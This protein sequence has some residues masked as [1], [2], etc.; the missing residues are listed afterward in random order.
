M[1]TPF[2]FVPRKVAKRSKSSNAAPAVRA[3][4]S[5]VTTARDSDVDVPKDKGKMK[6]DTI[7]VDLEGNKGLSDAD[8]ATLV[9]LSLS[10]HALWSDPDLRR[11][12]EWNSKQGGG[13]TGK[14]GCTF[15]FPDFLTK[16]NLIV[17][18]KTLPSVPCFV[19]HR[20]SLR[21]T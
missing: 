8:Y 13:H 3:S 12:L 7:A 19:V 14:E 17:F 21:Y 11:T 2:A 6:E 15:D 18:T 1:D 9:W 16:R 5:T 4:I 10:D 20:S